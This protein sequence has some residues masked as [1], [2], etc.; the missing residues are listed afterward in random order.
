[1]QAQELLA[2]CVEQCKLLTARYLAGFDDANRTRQGPGL[3]NHA[4]WN[5]GHLALTQ[6][7][8]AEMLDGRPA[9]ERDFAPGPRGGPDR[10]GLESVAFGSAPSDDPTAYPPLARCT[11]IYNSA[12]DRLARA[13]RAA[14]A[15][16]LAESVKWGAGETTL[17]LLAARMI[18]HNGFHTGQVA[19]LR[20]ALG[21][22]SIFG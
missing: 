8:V 22:K 10:F 14:P 9:P 19:D 12:C 6:H 4:A 16:K 13:I 11:E 21:M 20:R 18:F 3:P 7:R 2:Q 15:S 5:L 17:G 1:M